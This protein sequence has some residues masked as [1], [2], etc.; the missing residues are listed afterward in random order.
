EGAVL[1]YPRHHAPFSAEERSLLPVVTSF[2]SI[3]ISNAELYAKARAQA[4]ELHQIVSIASE[5]GSI[6][7]LDQFMR[8]FMHRASDFL[9]FG[10]ALLGL[11]EHEKIHL[12]W[13]HGSS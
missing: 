1:V 3:A 2:A 4:H 6:A 11:M 12:R 8:K 13:S 5:L 10:Q 9:G 7:D